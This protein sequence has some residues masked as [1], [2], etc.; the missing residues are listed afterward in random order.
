MSQSRQIKRLADYQAPAFL[1]HR[2]ELEFEL[3]AAATIVTATSTLSRQG[4]HHL[5]L[6]LDGHGFELMGV[7]LNDVQYTDY[8]QTDE[9]LILN[10]VPDEFELRIVTQLNP[11]QNT[12]LEGLYL[13]GGAYC[14]QC[15]AEGFRRIT[16]YQDRPDVL[17]VF[18]THIVAD[19][20]A[21]P[22]LLS[23]GNLIADTVLDSGKRRVSWFD[24]FPKPCYLFALVAGD[25]DELTDSYTTGSGREVALKFYVDKGNQ[26]RASFALQSL[27]R[28][29]LWD[30]QEF[31]L[32]YDLDIYMVVAVDFFNMGAMENKGLNVFN[33]KFVLAN[34]QT[35]TDIDYF[36]IESI[37]GHEY[38][39]NWTGNRVTCRDWFQLSL[40]EGLTVFRDQQFSAAMGSPTLCRIDAVKTIRTAQFAE[41]A[42]PMAHPIRPEQVLEMNNFY[43]VTVYDKGAEVIRMQHT[44]L[45]QAGFRRGMDLYF[46]RF[47]G[48]AVTC[49]DFVQ[50]MQDANQFDLSQ[51][52]R[53]YQQAGTP[54]LTATIEQ[55]D[56]R[57][58]LTLTLKQYTAPTADG[59]A[60]LALVIPVQLELISPDLSYRHQQ[61]LV[62][63]QMEQ[64][65][66]FDKVPSNL[67]VVLL[68]DFSAPVKLQQ[69]LT[70]DD[71]LFIAANA[72]DGVARWDAMQQIWSDLVRQSVSL[73]NAV[74]IPSTLL[75]MFSQ[76]LEKPLADLAFTA[77]LL[78]LPSYDSI[79]EQYSTIPVDDILAALASFRQQI[80]SQLTGELLR[81]YQSLPR[82][83]YQYEQQQVGVRKLQSL[84]LSYLAHGISAQ[85]SLGHAITSTIQIMLSQHYHQADNMTDRQAAIAAAVHAGLSEAKPLLQ[86]LLQQDGQDPLIFDKWASLQVSL[87]REDVF[88][89]I[90]NIT[91]YPQF[92]W[93]NPNRVRAVFSAF[94]HLN[95]RQF[96]RI[97][98]KGYQLLAKIVGQID[99]SNPQLAARLVTPLLSWQ[100]YDQ[101]RQQLIK[102]QLETLR[103]QSGLSNDLFE[104]VA[105][106][107]D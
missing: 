96:H 106:S 47:D 2:I 30:E 31:G 57:N 59:S 48:K 92:S 28:A 68:A 27:K 105:R 101:T 41:D 42:G 16:Y 45:G 24:P 6:Q 98:G 8:V 11:T 82:D 22:H 104:K 89:T 52:R 50:A 94:S 19:A 100:R 38:F 64:S 46:Q 34:P 7:W 102:N 5:P 67:R 39:H 95:P 20:A 4:N 54:E 86:D 70:L 18:T 69:Q 72:S 62:L 107:L 77:E 58:R 15:E 97:D 93:T 13:S 44:L 3:D 87:P 55:D 17:A 84:C 21:F 43:T 9:L 103:L 91:E 81:C 32:E 53:W 74:T 99:Q 83:S 80:A 26:Q 76:L 33:S 49:D 10:Q 71:L 29:M 79:A 1:T 90:Q 25:F 37:I 51:F 73:Q 36:N 85:V 23:N 12:A 14:T 60:K 35:A 65:F 66:E 56:S 63:D 40:K 75:A 88:A 61:L 78:S